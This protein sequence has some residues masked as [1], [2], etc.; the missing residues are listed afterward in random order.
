MQSEELLPGQRGQLP[1]GLLRAQ[2]TGLRLG[3]RLLALDVNGADAS[4]HRESP[5]EATVA[6]QSAPIRLVVI[7]DDGSDFEN[8]TRVGVEVETVAGSNLM[9][10]HLLVSQF[11]VG[12]LREHEIATIDFSRQVGWTVTASGGLPWGD[13][14]H[15]M[16]GPA[17]RHQIDER[18]F[19]WV[20]SGRYA[21][22]RAMGGKNFQRTERHWAVV[23]DSSASM[24]ALFSRANLEELITIVSGVLAESSGLMPTAVGA[25]GLMEPSWLPQP[26]NWPAEVAAE[27]T[28]GAQPA[29][30]T[31]VAP[32]LEAAIS[33]GS[34][35]VVVATDAVPADIYDAVALAQR[36]VDVEVLFVLASTPIDGSGPNPLDISS[37]LPSSGSGGPFRVAFVVIDPATFGAPETWTKLAADLVRATP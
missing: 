25:T 12:A 14:E 5:A 2:L 22:R 34:T 37:H 15:L 23:V 4:Q 20:G 16:G 7:P 29:S 17:V 24:R 18:E 1:E 32:A 31:L 13:F 19:P 26:A 33:A 6:P 11:D 35:T 3:A 21:L 27:V 36:R 28:D 30:W 9:S 10:P 8:G